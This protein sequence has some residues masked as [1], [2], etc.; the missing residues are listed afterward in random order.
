MATSVKEAKPAGAAL[1]VPPEEKFWKRY[2]PHGEA[3]LSLAGS[4]AVHALAVGGMML[5]GI[6]LASLFLKP[7]RSLPVDPVRLKIEGGGGGSPQGIGQ[8]KGVGKGAENI[9]EDNAQESNPSELED[10]PRRPALNPLEIQKVQQQF[11]E[12]SFRYIQESTSDSAKAFARLD[13]KLRNVLRDGIT[14]G[15]GKGGPGEGGGRGSGKGSGEGPGTGDGKASLS[16]R[17]KRMLR[18]HMTFTANTGQEYLQQL[19]GLGAILAFPVQDGPEPI[20]KVVEDL[21]PG[22]KLLD[23]DVREY[24]RIYWIDDKPRSVHDIMAALRISLPTIPSRFVAFMPEALEKK[25]FEKERQYVERVLKQ[26]FNEDQ[27]DET[28]FRVVLTPKGYEPELI[29]VTLR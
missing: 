1:R 7:N 5:F 28:T 3:P 13:D 23:K 19:R 8:G 9:G 27:I 21:R 20:F 6:Y 25:L 16:K 4:F 22:A 17:E 11:D 15:K 24:N 14:P 18:W 10:A 29:R 26:R 12:P 2:S